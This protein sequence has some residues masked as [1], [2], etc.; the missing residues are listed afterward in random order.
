MIDIEKV[1]K[2]N[3]LLKK[4]TGLNQTDFMKIVNRYKKIKKNVSK[5]HRL[6]THEKQIFF[7]V[8]IS[9]VSIS[10]AVLAKLFCV[11]RAR[12]TEWKKEFKIYMGFLQLFISREE[13]IKTLGTF[14]INFPDIQEALNRTDIQLPFQLSTSFAKEETKRL[15]KLV[16]TTDKRLATLMKFREEIL[17]RDD[18]MSLDEFIL[19][20]Y[21]K[22]YGSALKS[23]SLK[24]MA[25]LWGVS[26]EYMTRVLNV[27]LNELKSNSVELYE[28][29][30]ID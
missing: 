24:E 23:L 1:L 17:H 26:I 20:R 11:N 3:E 28:R 18:S 22:K 29:L 8:L 5:K 7:M 30:I 2:N 27:G 21:N 9:N 13:K 6:N 10:N 15:E 19:D 25:Y 16:I 14:L 12:V 4:L